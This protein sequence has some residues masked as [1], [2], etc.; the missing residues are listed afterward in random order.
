MPPGPILL[1]C[2]EPGCLGEFAED[3][4]LTPALSDADLDRIVQRFVRALSPDDAELI[5]SHVAKSFKQH[6]WKTIANQVLKS[7][8]IIHDTELIAK[9]I[10]STRRAWVILILALAAAYFLLYEVA[11]HLAKEK[12]ITM[13]NNEVTNQIRLQFQEPRI[14]NIVVS[15]AS[16]LATNL[17]MKQISPAIA[18]VENDLTNKAAAIQTLTTTLDAVQRA[19]ETNVAKLKDIADF[20]LLVLKAQNDDRN[21]FWQL[22]VISRSSHPQREL[23]GLIAPQCLNQCVLNK[24][25]LERT[26][27]GLLFKEIPFDP[28][29]A[30]LHDYSNALVMA[31]HLA[32]YGLLREMYH[33]NRFRLDDRLETLAWVIRTSTSLLALEEACSLMN[34]QAHI[35]RDLMAFKEYLD[36]HDNWT[37]TN[38]L[39]E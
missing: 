18:K 34:E 32:C 17:M 19:G 25:I 12:A 5:A 9:A 30:S 6:D 29:T 27:L 10:L 28:T 13:F 20:S 1:R 14:S 15:V 4:E 39:G 36:W 23:A 33:E 7:L 16:S 11:G 3:S 38:K 24:Q 2:P 8:N 26:D 31:P 37:K 35:G 21:A 22:V